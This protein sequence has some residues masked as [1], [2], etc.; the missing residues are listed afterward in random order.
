MWLKSRAP[1]RQHDLFLLKKGR[2]KKRDA[3]LALQG[4][5]SVWVLVKLR[6]LIRKGR[7]SPE[8]LPEALGTQ[9]LGKWLLHTATAGSNSVSGSPFPSPLPTPFLLQPAVQAPLRARRPPGSRT[10]GLGEK[11]RREDAMRLHP[12]HWWGRRLCLEPAPPAGA[13]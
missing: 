7:L 9:P 12:R 1:N 13:Q 10:G 6:Q 5:F 11:V 2:Q 3:L 8:R 4:H